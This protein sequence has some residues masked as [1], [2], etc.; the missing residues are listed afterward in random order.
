MFLWVLKLYQMD[1]AHAVLFVRKLDISRITVHYLSAKF[2]YNI[3][4]S[5]DNVCCSAYYDSR[6]R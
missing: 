5:L 4:F 3:I 1:V 2:E 6:I